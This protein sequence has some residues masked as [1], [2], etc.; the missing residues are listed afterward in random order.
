VGSKSQ[1]GSKTYHRDEEPAQVLQVLENLPRVL[2]HVFT[3]SGALEFRMNFFVVGHS[4]QREPFLN[5]DQAARVHEEAMPR[6]KVVEQWSEEGVREMAVDEEVSHLEGVPESQPV[7]HV[8]SQRALPWGVCCAV[9][10]LRAMG[11]GRRANV[12]S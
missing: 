7:G 11:K 2:V 6:C 9:H 12:I 8:R 5:L 10:H 1:S 3:F 4:H